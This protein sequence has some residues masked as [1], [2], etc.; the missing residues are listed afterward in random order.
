MGGRGAGLRATLLWAMAGEIVRAGGGRPGLVAGFLPGQSPERRADALPRLRLRLRGGAEVG[1][2]SVED[3][4]VDPVALCEYIRLH[5]K[6]DP[7][8]LGEY[9]RLRNG[10]DLDTVSR[11]QVLSMPVSHTHSHT[12]MHAS[13]YMYTPTPTHV[14]MYISM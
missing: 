2:D 12:C 6:D 3:T 4:V 13:M 10:R 5:E 11:W 14:C 9:I 8:A 1:D 7:V